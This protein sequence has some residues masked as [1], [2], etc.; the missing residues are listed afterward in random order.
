MLGVEVEELRWKVVCE[1]SLDWYEFNRERVLSSEEVRF[2]LV[3]S[4]R[5]TVWKVESRRTLKLQ[6]RR[7]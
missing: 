6:A 7:A 4:S 1:V 2:L 3:T 5:G